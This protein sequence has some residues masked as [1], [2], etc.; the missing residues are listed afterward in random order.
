MS[1]MDEPRSLGIAHVALS[2]QVTVAPGQLDALLRNE[3]RMLPETLAARVDAWVR[4]RKL[5]YYPAL[6]F[7]AGEGVVSAVEL[8]ALKQLAATIRK[9]AKRDVQ[10]RLWPIFSSVRIERA[11]SLAFTLPRLKPAHRDAVTELALP[12]FPQYRT[13]RADAGDARQAAPTRGCRGHQRDQG[14]G[15]SARC[16]RG[17]DGDLDPAARGL[18]GYLANTCAGSARALNSRASPLGSSRNIV[19]CSP[20]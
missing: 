10:T 3:D 11:V 13:H 19:A 9:R 16:V 2:V 6:E 4:E 12:L 5:G 1:A 14:N 7:L 17:G 18:S 20:T 8:D 15:Q